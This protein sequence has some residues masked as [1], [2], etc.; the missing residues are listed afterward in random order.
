[1][2]DLLP[3]L[4]TLSC[5]CTRVS[6]DG[7]WYR[8]VPGRSANLDTSRARAY[9]ACSRCGLL[10]LG[11]FSLVY[12]VSFLWKRGE[13]LTLWTRSSSFLSLKKTALQL[14]QTALQLYQ[15]Y[16]NVRLLSHQSKVIMKVILNRLNA[17]SEEI[18]A[19]FRAGRSVTKISSSVKS[20]FNLYH[21]FS[22]H[23]IKKI[24]Q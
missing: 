8:S 19:R 12:N 16:R 17:Q 15:N 21:V 23:R 10:F 3:Y 6:G 11:Y 20:A 13:W 9:C 22:L 18:I 7:A 4:C 2:A 14:Y 5:A 24:K 1:M